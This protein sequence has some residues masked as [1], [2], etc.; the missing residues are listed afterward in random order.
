MKKEVV[1][2][3]IFRYTI[4]SDG[5]KRYQFVINWS[6]KSYLN[7]NKPSYSV[8]IEKIFGENLFDLADKKGKLNSEVN[9]GE[10][11]FIVDCLPYSL[12]QTTY[13]IE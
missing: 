5:I 1:S 3:L 11:D 6:D 2:D 9:K 13:I 10:S 8:I 7:K 12:T 4:Y